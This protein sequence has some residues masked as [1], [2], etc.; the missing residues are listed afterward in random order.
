[1]RWKPLATPPRTPYLSRSFLS[2]LGHPPPRLFHPRRLGFSRV[3]SSLE[4]SERPRCIRGGV[5][6]AGVSDI[7][8]AGSSG[9]FPFFR[10][11]PPKFRSAGELRGAL[12][13]CL[14][15][16]EK[17]FPDLEIGVNEGCSCTQDSKFLSFMFYTYLLFTKALGNR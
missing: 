13:A 15:T 10:V 2:P 9:V 16:P 17:N 1:M 12:P 5:P 3:Q 6:L 4:A 11:T 8:G 7:S 14:R